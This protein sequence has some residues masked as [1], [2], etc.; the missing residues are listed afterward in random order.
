MD[1]LKMMPDVD[2][3]ETRGDVQEWSTSFTSTVVGLFSDSHMD[4]ELERNDE[5]S[6][7][8]SLAEMT[9]VAISRLNRPDSEGFILMVEGGRID[10]AHHENRAKMAMEETLQLEE[11]VKT[12]MEMTKREDTLILVTADHSHAVTMSGYPERGNPILGLNQDSY[13]KVTNPW[14]GGDQPY[15]TIGYANG[16][17]WDY[18]WDNETG[19][20]RN[21]TNVDFSANSFQQ[22]ATFHLDYE[23]HGGEDVTAYA[24]GPQ[25]HLVSGVHEQSYLAHLLAYAGCLKPDQL[26]CPEGRTNSAQTTWPNSVCLHILTVLLFLCK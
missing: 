19:F 18:H 14:T 16:P 2:Y 13:Y 8:P 5:V 9:R 11:A 12:V 20:W 25:A 3:L 6:G 7:Q 22:M 24:L 4:Y 1:R 21:L 15:T 10:H 23:T 26:G 17:G